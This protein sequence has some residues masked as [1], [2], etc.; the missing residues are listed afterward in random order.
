MYILKTILE[1]KM[2]NE[3]IRIEASSNSV[4]NKNYHLLLM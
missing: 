1:V 3:N 4:I 2:Q